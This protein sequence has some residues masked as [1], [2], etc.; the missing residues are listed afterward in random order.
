MMSDDQANL[1]C[2]EPECVYLERIHSIVRHVRSTP[3]GVE[4]GTS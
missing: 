1:H 3:Q 4:A 2:S